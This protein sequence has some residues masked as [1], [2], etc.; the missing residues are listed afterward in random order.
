VVLARQSPVRSTTRPRS[1]RAADCLALISGIRD[2][3]SRLTSLSDTQF[4]G[5]AIQLRG[6]VESSGDVR[7]PE[8][9]ESGFAFTLEAV[10][11]VTGKTLFDA[12][13]LGG[14]VLAQGAIAEM[15]TGEGK[16]LTGAA[17]AFIHALSGRG[18][19][20]MTSNSY[21]AERDCEELRPVFEMLGLTVAVLP[22]QAPAHEK[23]PL[24]DCD[25]VYGNGFEFGFDYL[26]D[27][28]ALRQVKTA[29][30][31]VLVRQRLT[32]GLVPR[33]T[34][35]RGL[36]YA[37]VDEADHVMLDDAISPL[38]ISEAAPGDAP[39]AEAH[40]VALRLANELEAPRDYEFDPSRGL[41][42]LTS[43][44]RDKTHAAVDLI[45]TD[46]LIR[47]WAL[48]VEAALKARL[49]FHRDREYIVHEDEVQIVD[50]STGRIM[51]DR[52]WSDGLHQAVLA[53]EGQRITPDTSSLARI[54]RQRFLRLYR[55][56]GG[57]TGTATGGEREFHSIY[58]VEV[59]P[60]PLRN[61][62]QRKMLTTRFFATA[63]AKWEA[64]AQEVAT[65]HPAGQPILIG[66]RSIAHSER[67]AALLRDRQLTFEL[68][69]GRQDKGEADIVS[70]A[71]QLHAITI[72]TNMAGRG[73]DIKPSIEAL[74][75]GGLHVICSEP[76]DSH[77]VDRQ[78]IGRGAR[79]GQPGSGQSF[80]SAEDSLIL[81]HG[82]ALASRI[83]QLAGTD[84]ECRTDLTPALRQLQAEKERQD[85]QLRNT[86]LEQDLRRDTILAKFLGEKT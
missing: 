39:D 11:R 71:G 74:A 23:R 41:V 60:I 62:T 73:T 40:R 38:L 83:I 79:Q 55:T 4:R 78:L 53:K 58:R 47:P 13:L 30:L 5:Y 77:R 52:T 51:P 26:R 67:L 45:P 57:M 6:N 28:I 86:L 34:M 33:V 56:L 31:G 75:V 64:I 12:Q 36:N 15:A 22:E 10:R 42:R 72:A 24:Y 76:Y 29:A 18:V 35:Q 14:L 2:V 44:G 61:P 85:S 8:I 16:T 66:T 84:L 63:K 20:V 68:L 80:V 1:R 65:R 48:Y 70:A 25:V 27:Q 81:D 43:Q 21:L 7:S 54:T 59:Q 32:G 9:L 37:I 19:H 3:A 46:I 82:R 17:P 49:L 50:G 69:N